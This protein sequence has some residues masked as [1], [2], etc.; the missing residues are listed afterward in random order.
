LPDGFYVCPTCGESLAYALAEVDSVVEVLD[1]GVARTSLTA[2]YGE[3]VSSSGSLHAPLPI[4]EAVFDAR[5][6]LHVFLMKTALRIAETAGPLTLRTSQGLA[7]YLITNL[8][9]LRRQEW[10]PVVEAELRGHLAKGHDRVNKQEGRVFAGQCANCDTDLYAGKQDAEAR[11][12]TCGATYEVLKWRAHAATAKNYYIG[13]AADLSRKLSAPQYGYTITADQIRKWALR[14][15]IT[16]ANPENDEQGVPIPPAYRLGDVLALNLDR[17]QRH[18][19]NG[20][21]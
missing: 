16:R 21:A 15:K 18:P 13:T 8:D 17:Y 2:G 7:S 10:A 1:A 20:A 12:R 14:E 9:I 4:N 11:C 3:R 6:A 19:I 5:R